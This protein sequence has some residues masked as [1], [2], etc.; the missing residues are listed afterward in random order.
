MKT[1]AWINL[2]LAAAVICMS[3]C[4]EKGVPSEELESEGKAK[5]TRPMSADKESFGQTPDGRQVDLYTLTNANG[6]RARVTN[7]GAI[8]V[9]LEVPDG[10]GNLA[11]VTLGYDSLGEY[12]KRGAFFGATVGRYANRIGGAKFVLNG[13]EYKLAA[14]NGPNHIHGGKKGFDKVVWRLE[15]LKAEGDRAMVR[16]SYV[17]EDGEEGYPGNLACCI[18]YALTKDDE[19]Q[20]SYEAETDKMTV[21]NLT[22]HS[23]FNLAGQGT[24]DVLD[25]VLMLN[26][27]KYTVFGQGLIPTGE[28]RSVKDS[29]LDFASPTPIGS[30]IQETENGYDHNYVLNSGG[31]LLAL[32]AR[33]HEPTSGRVMEVH[34]TEPGVQLYTGN[35]FDGSIIGKDGKAYKKHYGF[36]LE[37]QHFPDSPNKP[38]FPSVVL[39][40]G[41]KYTT[42]TVFKFSTL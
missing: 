12:I 22:N 21:V 18:T 17:S 1:K 30:R 16:M 25:H 27:D 29:P 6:L 2:V 19:L 41:Q 9:S 15:D 35:F 4:K 24:C 42:A 28:I 32:C 37:T 38:N 26:A 14:N 13:I 11:D 36:C 3:G 33:V 20:I 34:T 31:A 39:N 40:P 5:E 8:L 23:Y 7:Y 10:E